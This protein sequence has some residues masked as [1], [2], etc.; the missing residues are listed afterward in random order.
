LTSTGF[1]ANTDGKTINNGNALSSD[2]PVH[3][4]GH[5]MGGI[6]ARMLAY[7]LHQG[8]PHCTEA[9]GSKTCEGSSDLFKGG[10]TGCIRSVT[11]LSSPH[12]GT[13]KPQ[14]GAGT[15]DQVFKEIPGAIACLNLEDFVYEIN[16]W[17]NYDLDF[18][19]WTPANNFLDTISNYYDPS[20]CN[21]ADNVAITDS[22]LF[23]ASIC[24]AH[25]FN[26]D[27][28]G[29]GVAI[30]AQS[31]VYYFS[32]SNE[33]MFMCD[34][35]DDECYDLVY[36]HAN[37][38][39]W[40]Y[41][42]AFSITGRGALEIYDR[43]YY[44]G[45]TMVILSRSSADEMGSYDVNNGFCDPFASTATLGTHWFE[46]DGVT[47]TWSGKKPSCD[48]YTSNC[49][50]N[51]PNLTGTPEL[52]KWQLLDICHDDHYDMVGGVLE[53]QDAF[54]EELGGETTPDIDIFDWYDN[55][56]FQTISKLPAF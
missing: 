44:D 10:N 22:I 55:Y 42:A 41:E 56:I 33:Q 14:L 5:S 39:E 30:N 16:Q 32:V 27:Y 29:T 49:G 48:S 46:H 4:V 53:A 3:L 34:E 13:T 7:L 19:Q 9:V 51:S 37:R 54:G 36:G 2:Y 20:N 11:S 45:G 40:V 12:N 35:T 1:L 52:G 15:L 28:D 18:D 31:D 23:D 24:G 25:D 21:N 43:Q 17:V 47:P 50:V 26:N 8:S 6:T 38:Y